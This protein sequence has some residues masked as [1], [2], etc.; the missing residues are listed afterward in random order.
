MD[1]G[2]LVCA[3]GNKTAANSVSVTGASDSVFYVGG[4]SA[5]GVAP[6]N[7]AVRVSGIDDSGLKK[8]LATDSSGYQYVKQLP[9]LSAAINLNTA[10]QSAQ[11]AVADGYNSWT[12]KFDAASVTGSMTFR[13]SI[14][15]GT[16]WNTLSMNVQNNASPAAPSSSISSTIPLTFEGPIP[17]GATHVQV[18]ATSLDRKSTRLNSSHLKL[19][20]MPSSA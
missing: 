19:S 1:A 7:Q 11:L 8:T 16:N 13:F 3:Q 14:D 4:V 20:R 2:L 17:I 9:T 12:V 15:G 10:G 5:D 6:T 18:F